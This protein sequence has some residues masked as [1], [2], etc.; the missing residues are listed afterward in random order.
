VP[1]L[2]EDDPTKPRQE[3]DRMTPDERLDQI[4]AEFLVMCGAC[5]AGLP[6]GCA[7]STRD[8]RNTMSDLVAALREVLALSEKQHEPDAWISGKTYRD[9]IDTRLGAAP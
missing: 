1:G 3:G 4:E 6:M 9:A 7:C 8:P 2:R 5:D